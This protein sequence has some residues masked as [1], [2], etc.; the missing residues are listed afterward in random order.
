MECALLPG[1]MSRRAAPQIIVRID[2]EGHKILW[3][4]PQKGLYSNS[5]FDY[6]IGVQM[7]AR[8]SDGPVLLNLLFSMR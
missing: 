3:K 7:D 4:S 5:L 6:N 8:F 2:L 1:N